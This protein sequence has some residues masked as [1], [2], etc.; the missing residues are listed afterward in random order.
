MSYNPGRVKKSLVSVY[1]DVHFWPSDPEL[2]A[3]TGVDNA[4]YNADG[5]G[6]TF[7]TPSLALTAMATV[8]DNI[9]LFVGAKGAALYSVDMSTEL[10]KI[11]R[12]GY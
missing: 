8:E 7:A 6:K 1:P 9:K 4:I 12:A 2:I 10:V 5:T 11:Q 3:V